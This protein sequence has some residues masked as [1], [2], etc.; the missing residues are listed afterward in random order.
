MQGT[1]YA[2]GN[3]FFTNTGAASVQIPSQTVLTTATNVQFVTTANAL[4][5]PQCANPVPVPIQAVNQVITGH[6]RAGSITVIPPDS[7]SSIA[8][9]QTPTVT[10]DSLRATLTVNNPDPTTGGEAH[11]VPAVTQQ[12]LDK[13]KNDLNTQV[14]AQINAWKQQIQQQNA[15]NGLFGQPV[16]TNKRFNL[17]AIDTAE[18]NNTFPADITVTAT[19][20]IAQVNDAQSIAAKQLNN[21]VQADRLL[22]TRFAIIGTVSIDPAQQTPGDGNTVTVKV[23]GKAGP[24]LNPT[25]LQNSLKGKSLGDARTLLRQSNQRIQN[26]D[27]QTQPGIFWWVSPWADHIHVNILAAT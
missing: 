1:N 19:M 7:L 9:A 10:P 14:Q 2:K 22:G 8:Q 3:V 27:T 20:L 15:K 17:P 18:P 5:L 16:P 21:S 24:N 13:A 6:T 11:Q 4:I 25:D 23:T 12:D 26:V